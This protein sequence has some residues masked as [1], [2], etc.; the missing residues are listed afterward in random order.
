MRDIGLSPEFGFQVY[1]LGQDSEF[2]TVQCRIPRFRLEA[3][4]YLQLSDMPL[5]RAS[6]RPEVQ[7]GVV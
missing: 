5:S 6:Q 3:S 4:V 7:V 1:C 2:R